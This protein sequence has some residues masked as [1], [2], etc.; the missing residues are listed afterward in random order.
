[1]SKAIETLYEHG[2]VNEKRVDTDRLFTDTGAEC[3]FTGILDKTIRFVEDFQLLDSDNWARFVNQFKV[4]TDS[5]NNGWRGEY[6]GKMMRGAAFTYAYTRDEKLYKALC[7]TVED[8]LTAEDEFGRISSFTV[9]T[10]F[11]GWDLWCRKY[12]MLGMQYFME[13]CEDEDLKKRCVASM[14]RQCDYLI[15]KL[16][17]KREGKL[18]ITSASECW[19]G[20]NS[21]SI[22]EPVVRLYDLT[23]D[24]KYLDFASYIVSEGGTSICNIFDLAYEDK[25]DP[26]QY[27]VTKAY[28]MM[29]CFEGL[30]EYYRATGIERYK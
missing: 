12:V 14:C 5:E 21:S 19:R 17:P 1:M 29:S 18:P 23:G 20:L 8:M 15:S 27:P 24:K 6:W 28:E 2:T 13:I 3:A 25:T 7:D 11:H 22:L 30:L 10:E 26:Y 9:P 4:R 16:G